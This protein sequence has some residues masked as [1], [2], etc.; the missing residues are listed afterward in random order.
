MS[1]QQCNAPKE[2]QRDSAL[3]KGTSTRFWHGHEGG[4]EPGVVSEAL[5]P[6][7]VV[8]LA[9]GLGGGDKGLC[10]AGSPGSRGR[11]RRLRLGTISQT[12]DTRRETSA[13]RG[14]NGPLG[15][16]LTSRSRATLAAAWNP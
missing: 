4:A 8:L 12:I 7:V 6:G 15:I 14:Y 10:V 1:V 3:S 2:K 11:L 5:E 16:V 9:V 13:Y